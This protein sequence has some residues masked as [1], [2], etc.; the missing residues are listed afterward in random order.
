MVVCGVISFSQGV[1]KILSLLSHWNGSRSP[2]LCASFY[3]NRGFIHSQH[4]SSSN[5]RCY[6]LKEIQT[7][8]DCKLEWS[9]FLF[10]VS[11]YPAC[12]S[13]SIEFRLTG[14]VF[15]L[16][17]LRRIFVLM[18]IKT[19]SALVVDGCLFHSR[20]KEVERRHV[21]TG[22]PW[23]AGEHGQGV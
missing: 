8:L 21:D 20:K 12:L 7:T 17:N 5:L 23:E 14:R 6:L 22:G 16:K 1:F 11:V 4:C 18:N 19:F 15:F 2:F 9:V 3:V 10:A 13:R